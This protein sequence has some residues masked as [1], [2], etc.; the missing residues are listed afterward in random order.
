MQE[1]NTL[2]G[3]FILS[4]HLHHQKVN[5]P[6]WFLFNQHLHFYSR[7]YNLPLLFY[8]VEP[9]GHRFIRLIIWKVFH[10]F[11]LSWGQLLL[12]PLDPHHA[13]FFEGDFIVSFSFFMILSA[14]K[15]SHFWMYSS[16]KGWLDPISWGCKIPAVLGRSNFRG[17]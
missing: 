17:N 15:F 11:I 10:A 8:S 12:L 6:C 3:I 16:L 2:N 1:K 5:Y 9:I 7:L 4:K 14:D 13:Q